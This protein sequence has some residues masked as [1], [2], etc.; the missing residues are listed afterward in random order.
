LGTARAGRN[1][2]KVDNKKKT[3][4]PSKSG[5]GRKSMT[6]YGGGK[7]RL[8][9]GRILLPPDRRGIL[10]NTQTHLARSLPGPGPRSRK[11]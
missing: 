6:R 5:G 2:P 4:G 10:F 8:E 7:W 1:N 3:R 9:L 11:S